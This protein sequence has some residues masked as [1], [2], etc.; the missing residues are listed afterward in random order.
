MSEMKCLARTKRTTN[1]YIFMYKLDN[2]EE[3]MFKILLIQ[4][5]PS[6]STQSNYQGDTNENA[7]GLSLRMSL[8]EAK[9]QIR[10][11]EKIIA[12]I[13]RSVYL[14]QSKSEHFSLRPC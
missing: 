13:G 9:L 2:F 4:D 14:T 8:S 10:L 3:G 1:T 5:R 11:D 6:D 7:S 12:L